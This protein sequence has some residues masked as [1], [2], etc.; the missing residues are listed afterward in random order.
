MNTKSKNIEVDT[1][2]EIDHDL[3]TNFV[4]YYKKHFLKE[5]LANDSTIHNKKNSISKIK[6]QANKVE[7]KSDK[8]ILMRNQLACSI[9]NILDMIIMLMSMPIRKRKT[10]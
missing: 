7:I 6:I 5:N 10:M 9:I 8:K 1:N 2:S 3:I 4:K